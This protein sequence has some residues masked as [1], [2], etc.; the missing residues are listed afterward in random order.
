LL[1]LNCGY[2]QTRFGDVPQDVLLRMVKAEALE[3]ETATLLVTGMQSLVSALAED[4]GL[5]DVLRDTPRHQPL[6]AAVAAPDCWGQE[7]TGRV[8]RVIDTPVLLDASDTR[9]KIRLAGIDCPEKGQPWS[10]RAK[11]ALSDDVFN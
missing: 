11:Q 5:S 4:T 7:F 1:A 6:P 3:L 10:I 2:Y 8:V 9:R